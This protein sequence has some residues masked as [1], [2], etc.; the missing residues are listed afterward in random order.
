[1]SQMVL[2]EPVKSGWT[3]DYTGKKNRSL[4]AFFPTGPK[5]EVYGPDGE[6]KGWKQPGVEMSTYH[7][8]TRK[9]F[10]S[11][12]NKVTKG[13]EGPFNVTSSNPLDGVRLETVDVAR[14]SDKALEAAFEKALA[15]VPTAV[16]VSEKVAAMFADTEIED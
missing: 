8:G 15:L 7:W 16:E 2:P 5:V 3:W 11:S 10:T 4:S 13:V 6:V 12:I 1:M 14:Y 9:V